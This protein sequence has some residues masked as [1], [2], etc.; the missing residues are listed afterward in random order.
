MHVK[1]QTVINNVEM[2]F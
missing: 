2:S 1:Q